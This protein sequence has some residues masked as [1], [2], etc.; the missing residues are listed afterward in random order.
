MSGV[1]DP[2]SQVIVGEPK[3]FKKEQSK[4]VGKVV[5][6]LCFLNHPI[7]GTDNKSSVQ[8][9]IPQNQVAAKGYPARTHDIYVS[10]V[11]GAHHL[12]VP[13]GLYLAIVSTAVENEG[14][15]SIDVQPGIDLLGPSARRV[16]G[17]PY[18]QLCR[19][20]QATCFVWIGHKRLC[21]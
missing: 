11:S 20:K 13:K 3:Y 18:G 6:S 14:N 5:R 15:P 12:V 8:I 2:L 1:H 21:Q 4:L 7:P 17:P 19:T 16:G 9:I 10:L